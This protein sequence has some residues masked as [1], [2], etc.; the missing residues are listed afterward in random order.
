ML[1][2]NGYNGVKANVPPNDTTDKNIYLKLPYNKVSQ[3]TNNIVN[4]MN[5]KITHH[6]IKINAVSTTFKT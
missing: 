1:R 6:S 5:Q 4:E 2:K 3:L